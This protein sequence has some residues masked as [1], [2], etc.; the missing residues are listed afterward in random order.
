MTLAPRMAPTNAPGLLLQSSPF[1]TQL[2]SPSAYV[3]CTFSFRVPQTRAFLS[4]CQGRFVERK[5]NVSHRAT[6]VAQL[7]QTP[8]APATPSE[9]NTPG[10]AK[11]DKATRWLQE[12][13][14]ALR[15]RSS[16]TSIICL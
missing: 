15:S 1:R 9:D 4:Y 8:P 16:E 6:G 14:D 10:S 13:L 2:T 11:L 12:P 3:A 5:I 7:A